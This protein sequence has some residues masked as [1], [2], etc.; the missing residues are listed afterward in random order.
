MTGLQQG[1]F[2][3]RASSRTPFGRLAFRGPH[4]RPDKGV[5]PC[6]RIGGATP[7]FVFAGSHRDLPRRGDPATEQA[8]LNRKRS[9]SV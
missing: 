9:W 4:G 7:E 2:T 5:L 6:V 1:P 3:T 8:R